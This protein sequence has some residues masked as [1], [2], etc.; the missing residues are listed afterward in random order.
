MSEATKVQLIKRLK[1]L[2]WRVGMMA[3]AGI[4]QIVLDNLASFELSPTVTVL[5][6]LA[7]GEV[8]KYLNTSR[9]VVS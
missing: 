3:V 1:S 9:E 4:I 6:G 5:I 2:A 8:S 7:L